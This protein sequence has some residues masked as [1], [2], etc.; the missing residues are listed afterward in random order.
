MLGAGFQTLL[1]SNLPHQDFSLRFA[2]PSLCVCTAPGCS[3]HSLP[4][5]GYQQP[6]WV[7]TIHFLQISVLLSSSWSTIDASSSICDGAYPQHCCHCSILAKKHGKENKQTNKNRS[8]LS[9]QNSL[10]H[11]LILQ[12]NSCIQQPTPGTTPSMEQWMQNSAYIRSRAPPPPSSHDGS[13]G[14]L[15]PHCTVSNSPNSPPHPSTRYLLSWI[16]T[17]SFEGWV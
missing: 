9:E 14:L 3:E 16:F 7:F 10:K 8:V 13:T 1:G 4:L 17:L 12:P 15:L 5:V 2:G 11:N 6:Q